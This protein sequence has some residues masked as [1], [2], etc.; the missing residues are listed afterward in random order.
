MYSK[1]LIIERIMIKLIIFGF[2]A[3]LAYQVIIS[4]NDMRQNIVMVDKLEGKE[5]DDKYNDEN[6]SYITLVVT[7]GD[8][9][10][11]IRI[12][13]NGKY[14]KNIVNSNTIVYVKNNDIIELDTRNTVTSISVNIKYNNCYDVFNFKMPLILEKN[15]EIL[16]RIK[17]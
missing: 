4:N 3:L 9:N 17:I 13:L 1:H 10:Q 2:I 8:I 16:A 15:I 5:I 6:N 11:D 7:K 14:L 12:L